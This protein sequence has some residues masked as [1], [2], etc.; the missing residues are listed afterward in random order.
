MGFIKQYYNN[1]KGLFII[2]VSVFVAGII[3]GIVVA[4]RMGDSV[5]E[6]LAQ[7][8]D[9]YIT[10]D[11]ESRV[12]FGSVFANRCEDNLRYILAL[13]LFTSVRW[14]LPLAAL[15]PGVWGYRLGFAVSF[16]CGSFGGKGVALTAVSSMICYLI[17]IPLYILAFV[18]A[19]TYSPGNGKSRRKGDTVLL[20]VAMA[21]IY[22]I[23]C[24]GALAEGLLVPFALGIILR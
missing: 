11:N 9:G 24:L 15:L 21:V 13:L 18:M 3:G 8:L 16:V 12:T 6:T 23:L 17:I 2:A 1:N 20:L 4:C 5:A 19:V 22:G 14:F 7:Q 10:A